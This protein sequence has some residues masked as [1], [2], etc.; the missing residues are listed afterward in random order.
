M[1]SG[2]VVGYIWS[3]HV[4]HLV[5]GVTGDNNNL[6]GS[7]QALLGEKKDIKDAANETTH[8]IAVCY[9]RGMNACH[10]YKLT[11]TTKDVK[12]AIRTVHGSN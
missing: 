4:F 6:P 1:F 10:S 5:E 12:G 3:G 2:W 7:D 8:Q 11:Q 9:Y